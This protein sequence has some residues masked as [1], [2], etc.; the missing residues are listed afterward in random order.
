MRQKVYVVTN[1][2]LGLDCVCA[3]YTNKEAALEYKG[4]SDYIIITDVYL[5][6]KFEE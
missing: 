4:S 5:E 3:V 2:E 6:D 1:T